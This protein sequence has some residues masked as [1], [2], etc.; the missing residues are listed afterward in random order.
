MW[1]THS[2]QYK[3]SLLSKSEL[4]DTNCPHNAFGSCITNDPD[5]SAKDAASPRGGWNRH[6]SA[7]WRHHLTG[8]LRNPTTTTS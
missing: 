4:N 6:Q 8:R 1:L 7:K 5:P 3:H 2:P